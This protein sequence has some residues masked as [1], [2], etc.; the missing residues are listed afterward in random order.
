MQKPELL[1]KSMTEMLRKT[2]GNQKKLMGDKMAWYSIIIGNSHSNSK[3]QLPRDNDWTT[4]EREPGMENNRL[5]K[6]SFYES[7]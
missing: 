6:I 2:K 5:E 4:E 7:Y 1:E 3:R